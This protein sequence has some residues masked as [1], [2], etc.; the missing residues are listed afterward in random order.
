MLTHKSI[1]SRGKVS[2]TKYFQK[3]KQ[4]DRVAIVR[5]LAVQSPGFPQRMQ[6]RTGVVVSA[7]GSSYV[8]N[9]K[10]FSREKQYIVKPIHL[11]RIKN[12]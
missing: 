5:D 9:I 11:R 8:V 2:L 4:G 1:R 10:D 3:F 6:G 7:R 12:D